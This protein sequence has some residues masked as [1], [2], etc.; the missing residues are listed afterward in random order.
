MGGPDPHSSKTW[1]LMRFVPKFNK[2]GLSGRVSQI[3]R[4]S[5]F[6]DLLIYCCSSRFAIV[7]LGKDIER[8][9]SKISIKLWLTQTV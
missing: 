1:P 7:H 9:T 8:N 3:K 4:E 6:V 2:I 5:S